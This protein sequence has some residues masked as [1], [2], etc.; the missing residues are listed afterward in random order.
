MVRAQELADY[1][2]R[3]EV[4][5]TEF[6]PHLSSQIV[7]DFIGTMRLQQIL[8]W[9]IKHPALDFWGDCPKN[10]TEF[11][12][13]SPPHYLTVCSVEDLEASAEEAFIETGY[14]QQ[15]RDG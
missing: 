1:L 8:D 5:S 6:A 13:D 4:M 10:A 11:D 12:M 3:L 2:K 7:E 15:H 9:M 14:E